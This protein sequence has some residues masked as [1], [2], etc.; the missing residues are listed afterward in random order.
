MNRLDQLSAII[1][2]RRMAKEPRGIPITTWWNATEA[3]LLE[4]NRQAS[5]A[6]NLS[7]YIRGSALARADVGVW[8]SD[9]RQLWLEG[10]KLSGR[11]MA[12]EMV[13]KKEQ[14]EVLTTARAWFEKAI[15]L[16]DKLEKLL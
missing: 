4:Q 13:P 16:I 9:I 5:G 2:Y 6:P 3:G 15:D 12:L 11:V 14:Q 1:Y 7:K 10:N 8:H